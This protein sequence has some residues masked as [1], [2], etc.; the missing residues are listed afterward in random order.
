MGGV[1]D[2]PR[3]SAARGSAA[4]GSE[5][6]SG[7]DVRDELPAD[8]DARGFVGP[9]QFP[10]NSR[11]RYPAYVYWAVAAA[12]MVV[13]LLGKDRGD[14]LVTGGLLV[15]AAVLAVV[16]AYA[17]SAA[18]PMTVSETDALVHATR[19]AGFAVGH[20]SA[21]QVW[22]GWRSRPTWRV[23]CYSAEDPPLRRALVLV[24]AVDARVVECLSEENPEFRPPA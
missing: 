4:G 9:Y 13:W 12:C 7:D 16:G 20:A 15:A 8:L 11:R 14:G 18:W 19:A 1:S 10:D 23:L 21:Q 17:R 22:R 5:S 3:G 24:D 2:A 6:G